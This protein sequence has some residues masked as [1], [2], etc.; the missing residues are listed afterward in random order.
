[1]IALRDDYGPTHGNTTS[2]GEAPTPEPADPKSPNHA[3]RRKLPLAPPSVKRERLPDPLTDG[4]ESLTVDESRKT[5]LRIQRASWTSEG[6][7][8][9]YERH[10]YHVYPRIL[11]ADRHFQTCFESLTTGMFTRRLSPLDESDDWLT[12]WEC[13]EMLHGG[14]IHRSIREALNY[15]LGDYTSEWLA[16]TAPT[17]SAGT[18]HEHIYLWIDDPENSVTTDLLEPALDKHLKYCTNA[19]K[20][21]HCYRRDG[22]DG[23]ITVQQNPRWVKEPPAKIHDVIE[24]T[25]SSMYPN[26]AGA[27]YLASQLAHLPVGDFYDN[28]RENPPLALFEGAALA[29]ASPR[30]WFRAS[31]GVP[32]V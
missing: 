19:Y 7:T 22:T 1:M 9:K 5:Y 6:R 14:R 8:S 31:Q 32:A 29:W 10:R 26:T 21:H 28:E 18:P 27:Q 11:E 15:H 3:S 12:P 17:R 25:E 2:G 13:N 23:A 20:Q 16:V 4:E 24:E 30:N